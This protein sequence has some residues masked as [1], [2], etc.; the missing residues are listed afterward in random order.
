MVNA[1]ISPSMDGL[2]RVHKHIV[3]VDSDPANAPP[4]A[5][6]VVC[7]RLL[8]A[9]NQAGSLIGQQGGT[10]KTVQDASSC[11]IHVLGGGLQFYCCPTSNLVSEPH[12]NPLLLPSEDV[13]SVSGHIAIQTQITHVRS[14]PI[15]R[16]HLPPSTDPMS[17][18]QTSST[19]HY[20]S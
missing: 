10:I 8:V 5:G 19:T 16:H 6:E 2:L 20:P 18:L 9:A 15:N 4:G 11:T 7:T 3:D 14:D 17:P 1:S 13:R 12:I